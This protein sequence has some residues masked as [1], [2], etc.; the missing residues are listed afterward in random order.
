LRRAINRTSPVAESGSCSR[1]RDSTGKQFIDASG[2]AA[3]SC[4]GH[5]HP[6][7]GSALLV[8]IGELKR[9]KFIARRQSYHGITLGALSVGGRL[10]ARAPFID[11]LIDVE[12]VSACYA[13]R[14]RAD[15]TAK[16]YGQR[17]DRELDAR[18]RQLGPQALPPLLPRPSPAPRSVPCPRGR[19]IS[20]PSAR[21]AIVTACC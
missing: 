17:L 4:L 16:A 15:E 19:A 18:I 20:K 3:V 8:E 12:H 6:E 2:G 9:S 7:D 11:M 21:S 10:A 1:L 5:G 13:Y 14:E